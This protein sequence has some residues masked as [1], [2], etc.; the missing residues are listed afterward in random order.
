MLNRY[1]ELGSAVERSLKIYL[2][3]A[4]DHLYENN[5]LTLKL[6]NLHTTVLYGRV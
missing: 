1:N 3:S 2:C 6:F 4:R 5:L